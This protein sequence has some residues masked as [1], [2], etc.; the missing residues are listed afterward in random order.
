MSTSQVVLYTNRVGKFE[1]I[2]PKPF[3]LLPEANAV[4]PQA[5]LVYPKKYGRYSLFLRERAALWCM[6]GTPYSLQSP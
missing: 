4:M 1:K 5:F 2:T 3:Q 6:D